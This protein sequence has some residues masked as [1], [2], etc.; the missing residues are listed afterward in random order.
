MK[1]E[2]QDSSVHFV[3]TLN[4]LERR[5]YDQRKIRESMKPWN[6]AELTPLQDLANFVMSSQIAGALKR[7]I[8]EDT[9]STCP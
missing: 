3:R 5:A 2:S 4:S 8:D 1:I 7:A 6:S 9:K